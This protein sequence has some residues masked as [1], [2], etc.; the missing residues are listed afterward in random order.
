MCGKV[1]PLAIWD[2]TSACVEDH[3]VGGIPAGAVRRVER[4]SPSSRKFI[5]T[6][7]SMC[8]QTLSRGRTTA[9]TRRRAPFGSRPCLNKEVTCKTTRDGGRRVHRRL[10][11][12]IKFVALSASF[13]QTGARVRKVLDA[14]LDRKPEAT[15]KASRKA[16]A[17][18]FDLNFS[19]DFDGYWADCLEKLHHGQRLRHGYLGWIRD[20]SRWGQRRRLPS[21]VGRL[22]C[23]RALARLRHDERV[24]GSHEV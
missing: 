19:A 1:L 2:Q 23:N 11:N 6:R 15:S 24:N 12:I 17:N 7:T 9:P 8:A 22:S 21:F 20:G 4:C 14:V 3:F 16:M 5:S 10:R 13:R 18:E